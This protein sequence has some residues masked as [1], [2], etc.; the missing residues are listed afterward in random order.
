[1][2]EN[3]VLGQ[4]H[5]ILQSISHVNLILKK[6]NEIC[7]KP[8][9]ILNYNHRIKNLVVLKHVGILSEKRFDVEYIF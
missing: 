1:M 6:N 5:D 4:Q 8:K 9:D 2:T 3:N 7:N